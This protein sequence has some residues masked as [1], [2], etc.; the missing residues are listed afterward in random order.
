MRGILISMRAYFLLF[1]LLLLPLFGDQEFTVHLKDP[2]YQGGVVSTNQGGVIS[3][4]ELRIQARHIFYTNKMEKGKRIHQVVAEGDLM[5]ESGGRVYVGQRLEYDFITK[6]G[7]VHEGVTAVD[8]WFLGGE[9]IR[10]NSDKSFY[11]YNAF[12]TTSESKKSDWKIQSRELKIT[13]DRLLAADNVTFRFFD[14]PIL[15]LPAFKSNLKSTGDSPV[16]YSIGWEKK[17]SPKLGMRYRI[18]SWEQFDLF[19]K[20][21]VRPTK[22]VGGALESDYHSLDKRK[23]FRTRSYLDHDVFFRD[24]NSKKARTHYRLQGIYKAKTEDENTQFYATY[25]WLSDRNMQTD[26][27]SENFELGPAKQTR[28]EFRN[29]QDWMIVG[30]DGK[31]R[32][33]GFQGMKQKLPESFWTPRSFEIGNSGIISENRFKVAYL[34]YVSA[35]DIESAVPDFNA[36]R[37]S[38]YNQLYRPFSFRG[39]TLTPLIGAKGVFYSDSQKDRTAALGVLTYQLLLDLTLKK[40]YQT[41]RHVLKPYVYY[42]GMTHPTIS[43]TTPYIFSTQDGFNRFNIIQSGVRNLFFS[44]KHPLF[45]PNI[46]VDLHAYAFFGDSTFK[47]TIPKLRGIFIWNFPSWKLTGRVGWNIEEQTLNYANVGLAWTINENFAF[48]TEFRHRGRF[49]WRDNDP[50]NF[51]ME[52]TRPISELLDSPLSDGR[53]TL[54]SRL[55]IKLAPQWTARLESHIGWGRGG[56]PNYNEAKVDLITTIS[57]SWRLRLTVAH[58]L[59]PERNDDQVYGAISVVK[60]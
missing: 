17:L 2:E 12:V 46:V 24:T 27:G 1:L 44:K 10:L 58:T 29:Y 34:D 40:H 43:P 47:K 57:T 54:L 15:W 37:L 18:Y 38:T 56:E 50:D 4:P 22:G 23:E 5:L 32:V 14:T 9:K 51:I 25:D 16:R 36:A 39:F 21:N 42:N 53:N 49:D 45:D 30:V 26:F 28:L 55:Q 52:V 60:Q 41:V 7:V 35:R 6:T 31:F 59:T 33:N 11:L 19:F 48:K 13:K 8:M 20:L 3:S